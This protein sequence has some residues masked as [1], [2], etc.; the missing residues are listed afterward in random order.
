MDLHE[1]RILEHLSVSRMVNGALDQERTFGRGRRDEAEWNE[2]QYVVTQRT[3][4]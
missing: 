4:R 1:D 2:S 3:R